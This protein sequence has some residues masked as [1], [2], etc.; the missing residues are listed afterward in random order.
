[1]G[2]WLYGGVYGGGVEVGCAVV[3]RG[4]EEG[5]W[6]CSF[7][8]CGWIEYTSRFSVPNNFAFSLVP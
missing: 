8:E 4:G 6:F 1:M 2:G 7:G 5:A 3:A